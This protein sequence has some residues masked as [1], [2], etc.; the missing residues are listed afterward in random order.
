MGNGLWTQRIGN[1]C[2][3]SG[4]SRAS[5]HSTRPTIIAVDIPGPTSPASRDSSLRRRSSH[6]SSS[7]QTAGAGG[8]SLAHAR[9]TQ[10][11]ECVNVAHAGGDG[12]R[13]TAD[14]PIEVE[15][16]SGASQMG[17]A[18]A[19]WVRDSSSSTRAS[20]QVVRSHASRGDQVYFSPTDDGVDHATVHGVHV[21]SASIMGATAAATAAAASPAPAPSVRLD[22][23]GMKIEKN[24]NDDHVTQVTGVTPSAPN[25]PAVN[26][27]TSA[28][29]APK[30]SVNNNLIG[31]ENFINHAHGVDAGVD[32][33]A[34]AGGKNDR[35][36]DGVG[37]ELEA[38]AHARDAH[39]G[40]R[41]GE[42]RLGHLGARRRASVV[43]SNS[44]VKS[45]F[46]VNNGADK[47]DKNPTGP[48][49]LTHKSDAVLSEVNEDSETA[50]RQSHAR[51]EARRL[52]PLSSPF[53]VP[54]KK[55]RHCL[56]LMT[57]RRQTSSLNRNDAVAHDATQDASA[58][59]TDASQNVPADSGTML[60]AVPVS[61]S[62]TTT[63]DAKTVV[64]DTP[65]TQTTSVSDSGINPNTSSAVRTLPA[66]ANAG[67]SSSSVAEVESGSV[68][69][70]TSPPK[71]QM[72][73]SESQLLPGISNTLKPVE[74][75]VRKQRDVWTERAQMYKGE[76][77][78]GACDPSVLRSPL[79]PL[80]TTR[81]EAIRRAIA[82]ASDGRSQS[83]SSVL[84]DRTFW[85]NEVNVN[86]ASNSWTPQEQEVAQ[87]FLFVHHWPLR[88]TLQRISVWSADGS[89]VRLNGVSPRDV[90]TLLY[91]PSKAYKLE[92]A[93]LQL[94]A[95]P[96]KSTDFYVGL[97]R[98][99]VKKVSALS[100]DQRGKLIQADWERLRE[101]DVNSAWA[102]TCLRAGMCVDEI[103][104]MWN[105]G[106][107]MVKETALL[108]PSDSSGMMSWFRDKH[109]TMQQRAVLCQR[110]LRTV[111]VSLVVQNASVQSDAFPPWLGR[112]ESHAQKALRVQ[113]RVERMKSGLHHA[114]ATQ[115]VS[116][117][118][119]NSATVGAQGSS[120]SAQARAT[121]DAVGT[122]TPKP[123]SDAVVNNDTQRVDSDD[124]GYWSRSDGPCDVGAR[125]HPSKKRQTT[126]SAT[127]SVGA[128]SA[129][130]AHVN[131][132]SMHVDKPQVMDQDLSE[133]QF[134]QY[135]SVESVTEHRYRKGR[136]VDYRCTM[137]SHRY[138][139]V[140]LWVPNALLIEQPQC[141]MQYLWK[142]D[143]VTLHTIVMFEHRYR[144]EMMRIH[145]PKDDD[146]TMYSLYP[147]TM[148][149]EVWDER[150]PKKATVDT[151][152]VCATQQHATPRSATVTPHNTPTVVTGT[153]SCS[154]VESLK[155]GPTISGTR[156]ISASVSQASSLLNS[157]SLSSTPVH[158]GINSVVNVTPS[159]D[160][161]RVSVGVT[162]S[163]AGSAVN[164][165][166]ST[167]TST[168]PST[169]S[170]PVMASADFHTPTSVG[171]TSSTPCA[172]MDAGADELVS[173]T[174][175]SVSRSRLIGERVWKEKGTP[176]R[177]ALVMR[178]SPPSCAYTVSNER[179]NMDRGTLGELTLA[180]CNGSQWTMKHV[181][182]DE[183]A[184][185]VHDLVGK[186]FEFSDLSDMSA[187]DIMMHRAKWG[188]IAHGTTTA[189]RSMRKVME[190]DKVLEYVIPTNV[191]C[192]ADTQINLFQYINCAPKWHWPESFVC[193]KSKPLSDITRHSWGNR[194]KVVER[195]QW[196]HSVLAEICVNIK[197][198]F[199]NLSAVDRRKE[200]IQYYL[201]QEQ[202]L[203][204]VVLDKNVR[205]VTKQSGCDPQRMLFMFPYLRAAG[206]L[207]YA[208]I[209]SG[210]AI[211][212]LD[213]LQR[214]GK[215]VTVL[216][217]RVMNELI[218]RAASIQASLSRQDNPLSDW[219]EDVDTLVLYSDILRSYF[220]WRSDHPSPSQS[221][222]PDNNYR[223]PR[224]F[225]SWD[226]PSAMKINP[227]VRD[228]DEWFALCANQ[229]GRIRD[230]S[231]RDELIQLWRAEMRA[232]EH[233]QGTTC[234]NYFYVNANGTL[235]AD[236]KG[237]HLCRG[238]AMDDPQFYSHVAAHR[239]VPGHQV[240]FLVQ[241]KPVVQVVNY[242]NQWRRLEEPGVYTLAQWYL[243][244]LDSVTRGAIAEHMRKNMSAREYTRI[245]AQPRVENPHASSGVG[246]SASALLSSHSG[247]SSACAVQGS[248]PMAVCAAKSAKGT[249]STLQNDEEKHEVTLL[250]SKSRNG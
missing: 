244:T 189:Q 139:S 24:I 54:A 243:K 18:E 96:R 2:M 212:F 23:I 108:A 91:A 40:S 205:M 138:G 75:S 88:Y 218:D 165:A 156:M 92:E 174:V 26:G 157:Q 110:M 201:Y 64:G 11:G 31:S 69:L 61:S 39:S 155:M 50:K 246:M 231:S 71:P 43:G 113:L 242:F 198:K 146:S 74:D 135:G 207:R 145:H 9:T 16:D 137:R 209:L 173:N 124:E 240:Q 102:N 160:P 132:A 36:V 65:M 200:L 136:S 95:V 216:C 129:S 237:D 5:T 142:I 164:I 163:D 193:L 235:Q 38:A 208:D 203:D 151:L 53:R 6:A 121:T 210:D 166:L 72:H 55:A 100:E 175:P 14:S 42:H 67:V 125:W 27:L 46:I 206:M 195:T 176:G 247:P 78:C 171:P 104:F 12:H 99:L 220:I 172:T 215:D 158:G 41:D 89:F 224:C 245:G 183:T 1:G 185:K 17:D 179:V 214:T 44:V 196:V 181:M 248:V 60:D 204:A 37:A 33:G 20:Q 86:M 81:D 197:S 191:L 10:V 122:A 116:R 228:S 130:N 59:T 3:E 144:K 241:Y 80:P 188:L 87:N 213:D 134:Q 93:D 7:S 147:V 162:S 184:I 119:S 152:D 15:A 48:K 169:Q 238:S 168:T 236:T 114:V 98:S 153:R 192:D 4:S 22:K 239:L 230:A 250:G 29:G 70:I 97:L 8:F 73:Q 56:M 221:H 35:G 21:Q 32:A 68:G 115:D 109:T 223:E 45:E 118:Q 84:A 180:E 186:T 154:S 170:C 57:F 25:A 28:R 187:T 232:T 133:Q 83:F 66:G 229:E 107:K 234:N 131:A 226:A 128:M 103:I 227:L 127:Q 149:E 222:R 52:N 106:F 202:Q 30:V 51:E 126:D 90:Q 19:E 117:D 101:K 13:S 143:H 211:A 233:P 199:Y 141:L 123:Q 111:F 77:V 225:N 82:L 217:R 58:A 49:D 47:K 94:D 190:A 194:G 120:G 167:V 219:A 140:Q 63:V 112:F 182:A 85:W 79:P 249:K 177:H 178:T 150:R 62:S 161:S 105:A 159:R 148:A 76:C 34:S